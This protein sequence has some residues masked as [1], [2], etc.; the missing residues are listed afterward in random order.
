MKLLDWES[1]PDLLFQ[2]LNRPDKRKKYVRVIG[3]FRL[4]F[5]TK[6]ESIKGVVKPLILIYTDGRQYPIDRV[7]EPVKCASLKNGGI[8]LR[9]TCRVQKTLLYLYFEN[10][11]WFYERVNR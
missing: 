9:Y 6:I 2:D 5:D 1:K 10:N 11:I 4:T 3:D 8:R 7:S